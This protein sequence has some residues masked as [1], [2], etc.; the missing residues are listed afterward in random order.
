MSKESR[1]KK[2]STKNLSPGSFSRITNRLKTSNK[3][4]SVRRELNRHRSEARSISAKSNE[5]A[6][7][8]EKELIRSLKGMR[9]ENSTTK[10]ELKAL[11]D[12]KLEKLRDRM[13][14]ERIDNEKLIKDRLKF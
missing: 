13:L 10:R 1:S 5:N 12:H 11:Y 3:R 7:H 14:Q 4:S 8:F 6:Y 2:L 9:R